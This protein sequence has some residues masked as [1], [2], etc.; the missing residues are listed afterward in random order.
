[1]AEAAV[2]GDWVLAARPATP[3][4]VAPYG[5]LLLNGGRER[6]GGAAPVLLAMDAREAGPLRVR[7]LQRYPDA[8]RFLLALSDASFIVV[9]AGTGERPAGPA[10]ALRVAGGVGLV[11]DAGVWHAGPILMA[12]ATILE[13]L[14]TAGPADRLD[15]ASVAECL[16]AEGLRIVLPD[17]PGAPGPGL[18]L[19][20]TW[21]ATISRDLVGKLRLA[22]LAF[23]RLTVGESPAAL[24]E[25]GDRLAQELVRQHGPDAVPADIPGLKPARELYRGLGIDPTKTRPSSEALLR[26]VLAGKP[27]YRIN[28]L[29]D[30][31]NLCSLRTLVPFGAYDRARI[32]G[33][34][35]VRLGNP[36][37]G[38]E[39]IGRGRVSV[40]RRP[41]L[42]DREGAFGNP[43]ADSLRTRIVPGTTRAL[44]VLY[45]PPTMEDAAISR[46][47]DSV[48]E[49]VVRACGGAETGRRLAP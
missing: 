25:E 29:V 37:E 13:A 23:D 21:S 19:A 47:L 30:A 15:R 44:V 33:P 27:L 39:G 36:G 8:R 5:R 3:E 17:E 11:I 7:H 35:V 45:L 14:E 1:M 18:D 31:L 38:Y 43:T 24:C 12:D 34:L 46:L 16:G 49:T 20:E 4:A 41:V 6:F 9:V 26:R 40:E 2:G 32:A 28:S 22:C 10:A 42:A 48:A